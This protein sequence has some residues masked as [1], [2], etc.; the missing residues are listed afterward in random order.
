MKTIIKNPVG[1]KVERVLR[2]IVHEIILHPDDFEVIQIPLSSHLVV[3]LR[4]QT[5]DTGRIIGPK[6]A[7]FLALK[8]IVAAVGASCTKRVLLGRM[9]PPLD[10]KGP[11]SYNKLVFKKDWNEAKVREILERT[12]ASIFTY[13]SSVTV[14]DVDEV[15]SVLCVTISS[16]ERADLVAQVSDA[17][18]TLFNAVG[19]ANGRI[20]LVDVVAETP[21]PAQPGSADGRWAKAAA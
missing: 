7:H 21:E 9:E 3:N 5:S 4:A 12:V 6:G 13:P 15:T 17:L 1:E 14:K 19:K 18:Q 2:D 20:V 11:D 10:G 16:R 8:I